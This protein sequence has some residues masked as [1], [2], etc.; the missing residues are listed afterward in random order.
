MSERKQFA[1]YL[2]ASGQNGTFYSGVTSNLPQRIWQHRNHAVPGF[3]AK[4]NVTRLVWYEIH[5]DAASAITR[6]KRIKKWNR[7]WKV[8][9]LERDNPDWRDLYPTIAAP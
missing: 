6:E 3:T 8:Q 2:L 4:Y 7:A 5:D 9:L 1:V